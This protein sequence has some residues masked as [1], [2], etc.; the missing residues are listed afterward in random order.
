MITLVGRSFRSLSCHNETFILNNLTLCHNIFLF[1]SCCLSINVPLVVCSYTFLFSS[2]LYRDRFF[3]WIKSKHRLK[4]KHQHQYTNNKREKKTGLH[5]YISLFW[6]NRT[7]HEK[8]KLSMM[9][10]YITGPKYLLFSK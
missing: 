8:E 5:T 4:T 1:F 7:T 6:N 3:F 2:R 9:M 10:I